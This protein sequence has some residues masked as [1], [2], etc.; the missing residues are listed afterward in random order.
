MNISLPTDKQIGFIRSLISE[1][2]Q[3]LTDLKPDWLSQAPT[4]VA[5]ASRIISL[6]K[7]LPTD[8]KV[9]TDKD[10]EL[11]VDI[12]ILKN[13][14]P[15]LKG[16]DLSFATS[17]IAQYEQKGRLSEKQIPYVAKLLKALDGEA[18]AP[19]P[20]GIHRAEDGTIVNVYTTKNGRV[21]GKVL[22]N[23]TFQWCTGAVRQYGLSQDT[24]MTQEDARAF[25]RTNG[26]CVACLKALTDDRSLASGYGQVCASKHGWHYCTRE[27]AVA[28]LGRP[29]ICQHQW[30]HD[31]TE[32][33][34]ECP[35]LG[36]YN[37]TV[38]YKC[39][40]C[41]EGKSEREVANYSGD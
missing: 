36:T 10:E 13:G 6:L 34:S 23:G 11:A 14:L 21:G 35:Q 18:V 26:F 22:V 7:S 20:L 8:P 33:H 40:D 2:R 12:A 25:G 27:E 16:R 37:R 28:I 24:L 29:V 30:V 31:H 4:T 15:D 32:S 19:C 17:L 5:E 3:V 38:H 39:S 1:R 41:G 9:P